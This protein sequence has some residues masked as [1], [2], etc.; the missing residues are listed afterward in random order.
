M[1][2]KAKWGLALGMLTV[3]A[4]ADSPTA[5]VIEAP[6]RI[7]VTSLHSSGG[8]H[9]TATATTVDGEIVVPETAFTATLIV[10]VLELSG[11]G[12]HGTNAPLDL[13]V[14]S[15]N[16]SIA[17]WDGTEGGRFTGKVI[18]LKTGHTTLVFTIVLEESGEPIFRSA[19][20][21]VRVQL[22]A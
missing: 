14:N 5:M 16:T 18:G 10:R 12:Y 6:G 8:I 7:L 15:A 21:P 4:C 19:P 2:T 20:I 22:A 3:A 17:Y 9:L 11:Q 13:R 1:N